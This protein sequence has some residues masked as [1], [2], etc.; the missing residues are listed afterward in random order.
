MSAAG[1]SQFGN[2]YNYQYGLANLFPMASGYW[3][4][5]GDAGVFYRVWI[6]SRSNGSSGVGFRASAYGN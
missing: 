1:T 5:A 3:V 4:S 2:D 6:Y